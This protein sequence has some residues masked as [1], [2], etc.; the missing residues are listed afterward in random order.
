[1]RGLE[2]STRPCTGG[3]MSPSFYAS[4]HAARAEGPAAG[5][6]RAP[7]SRDQLRS[8]EGDREGARPWGFAGELRI[9]GGP[10]A[11]TIRPGAGAPPAAA[12]FEAL[13]RLGKGHPQGPRRLR[14]AGDRAGYRHEEARGL[15]VDAGR[16]YRGR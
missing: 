14:V 2:S 15:R 8:T 5:G 13:G 11:A 16:I 6:S 12:P 4:R 3:E 1:M 7:Q 9:Q 10:G